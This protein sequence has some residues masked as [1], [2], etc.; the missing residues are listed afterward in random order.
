MDCDD[1]R[2]MVGRVGNAPA[3]AWVAM[4]LISRWACTLIRLTS[5]VSG[6]VGGVA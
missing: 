3:G 1:W 2:R 6:A 4:A 5:V